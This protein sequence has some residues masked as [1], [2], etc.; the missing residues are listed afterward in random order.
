MSVIRGTRDTIYSATI[1]TAITAVAQAVFPIGASIKSL[2]FQAN[3][4][5]GSGG[6]S[7]D[8]WIQTSLDGG[9][10]WIDIAN[11]RFTT[12]SLR[13]LSAVVANPATAFTANTTASDGA[14]T[15]NTVLNG[16]IGDRIRCKVTT[17]GTYGG[18]TTLAVDMVGAV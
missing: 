12:S 7:A 1:T 15:A 2:M 18:G 6:T 8:V 10:T 3:F 14:L 4:I 16:M 17:V 11:F 9:T 13:K 5:Y